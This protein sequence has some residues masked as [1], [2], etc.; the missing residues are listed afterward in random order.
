MSVVVRTDDG[1]DVDQIFGQGRLPGALVSHDLDHR[2]L[3]HGCRPMARTG[4]PRWQGPPDVSD[5]LSPSLSHLMD[6]S[7]M[8]RYR[9]G[10]RARGYVKVFVT[11]ATGVLGQSAIGA[12]ADG[13]DVT[14]LA[15]N[16]AKARHSSSQPEPESRPVVRPRVLIGNC[17]FEAVCNLATNIPIGLSGSRRGAWKVNDRLRVEGSKVVVQAARTACVRR[18]VQESVSL[19]YAD[20]GD[21][22]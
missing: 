16:A 5:Y 14:G 7:V 20:G 4:E 2:G 19:L 10:G 1:V 6:A 22:S 8:S 13:H 9:R 3:R 21:E 18:F 15:R 11:G 17:G 12:C